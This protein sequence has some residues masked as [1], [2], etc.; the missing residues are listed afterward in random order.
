[1]ASETRDAPALDVLA[2]SGLAK[3]GPA[4]QA[5]QATK[6]FL[7]GAV[8]AFRNLN[9]EIKRQE[10]LCIVGPSGCGKTT[11]LR[12]IAGLT[13]ISTGQLLVHGKPVKGPPDGVAMV[14]QHFGLLPW[15]TVY[16][17]AAF[18]VRMNRVDEATVRER[19]TRYLDLVGLSGFERSFPHQLSGGMQQR[20]GL[21]RAL[22]MNPSIML[23]D[24]P[25]AALDAQTRET[26]Q[27]EL[28]ALMQR[29]EERKAMVFITHSIDEAL[30]LADRIA[31]MTAR[32]GKID[33][34]LTSPFGWPRDLD[35]VQRN[36]QFAEMRAYIRGKLKAPA[37]AVRAGAGKETA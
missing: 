1:M 9:L 12:S 36:P 17:N 5:I 18:G 27:E 29:P 32:P 6:M 25:F 37:P 19:V 31:V 11:L 34:I 35:S 26:L 10:I 21:V 24:E 13:G 23:M 16:D 30:L 14:F 33:E 4:V 7:D 3:D 28:L 15:K 20:V 8:I 2:I 22:A